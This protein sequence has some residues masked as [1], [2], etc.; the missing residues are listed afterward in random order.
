MPSED[1]NP[2]NLPAVAEIK[3]PSV[4]EQ[5]LI[6]TLQQGTPMQQLLGTV[7]QEVGGMDFMV[8]WAEEFPT[9]FIRIMMAANPPPIQNPQGKGDTNINLVM[10]PALAPGPLDNAKPIN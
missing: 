3:P 6:T 1:T 4:V 2:S 8:E 7:F 5:D 9:E 10:H